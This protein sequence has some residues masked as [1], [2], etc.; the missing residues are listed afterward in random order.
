MPG[1]VSEPYPGTPIC[2]CEHFKT[3]HNFPSGECDADDCDC[4]QFQ[5]I[6]FDE[7]ELGKAVRDFLHGGNQ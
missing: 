2:K 4:L 5:Q 3:V 7:S 1:P 6:N